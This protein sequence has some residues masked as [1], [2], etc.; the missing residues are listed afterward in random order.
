MLHVH[1]SNRLENLLSGLLDQINN[2]DPFLAEVIVVQ[3]PGMSRWLSQQIAERQGISAN[4]EFVTP[5]NFFWRA[6]QCWFD[7]LKEHPS[8]NK[9]R[10]QWQIFQLLPDFLSQS[11]FEQLAVYLR[12]DEDTLQR[13]QLSGAIANTFDQYLIYRPDLIER[14]QQGKDVHWQALLWRAI[15]KDEPAL[16]WGDIRTRFAAAQKQSPVK[17]MPACVSVFGISDLA[18]LYLDLLQII[19]GHTKTTLYYLNPCVEYWADIKDEKSL[20]RRRARAYK[21]HNSDTD[22]TGLLDIVNPLLASWGHAGQSFLDQLLERQVQET[23]DYSVPGKETLLRCL[24]GDILHLE[25]KTD[26]S[27]GTI[28]ADDHSVQIHSV[29]STLRE[30][31]VLHDQLLN[32]FASR[33]NLE[34]RDIIVMAPDIDCYAPFVDAVFGTAPSRQY[35]PWSISDRRLRSEQQLLEAFESLLQLPQSRFESTDIVSL[36]QVPAIR[37]KFG[38]DRNDLNRLR[39]WIRESGVR[40][41]LDENMRTELG[42]P[43]QRSHSWRYGLERMFLGYALPIDDGTLYEGISPYG[44]IEG[45]AS[46]QLEKLQLIIDLCSEWRKRLLRDHPA[47]DWLTEIDQLIEVFFEP[48]QKEAHA[49]QTLRDGLLSALNQSGESE[50]SIGLPVI[51]EIT[52]NILEDNASV[53]QFLT[54]RVTFSNIVPMRSIPFR[55]VCLLGMNADDFPRESRPLS[56]DL[57]MQYPR[58]GD[59]GRSNDD[60]YLFLETLLSAR[61]VLYLSYVGKD[62]RDN[63]DKAPATVLTEMLS[64]TNSSY[65]REKSDGEAVVA[66][67]HPLQPFSKRY[68]DQS[69]ARL[70]NFKSDWFDAASTEQQ[71]QSVAFID[72]DETILDP[73]SQDVSLKQLIDF[74]TSPAMTYLAERL[75]VRF[76][77]SEEDLQT[78]EQ[79]DLSALE[80]WSVDQ[81]VHF[82]GKNLPR[83]EVKQTLDAQ[84]KLP[85]GLYGDIVFE[86]SYKRAL[87]LDAR[88]ISHEAKEK[89]PPVEV[90]L[91][92]GAYTVH[93]QLSSL[94]DGGLFCW[95]SGKK[96][97]TDILSMWIKHLC[98]CAQ[99]PVQVPMLSTYV[100]ADVTLVF[101]EVNN[102]SDHLRQ[103]LELRH[104][105]LL[106]PQLFYPDASRAFAEATDEERGLSAANK[107]WFIGFESR[108]EPNAV[109]WRGMDNPFGDG[110]QQLAKSVF[111][112]I[113]QCAVETPESEEVPEE[114]P[115]DF[116]RSEADS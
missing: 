62:I 14:W 86:D 114:L 27:G 37:R 42:L 31:Q 68:F 10:L 90:A 12:G 103:L 19:A 7:D 99:K 92:I 34:P 85:Q 70:Y 109:V 75:A 72:T 53:R 111:E 41:S 102:P 74:I 28:A 73:P 59:R 47:R 88:I 55:V 33:D 89:L 66:L 60:R 95:R 80:K 26:G 84:G 83:K 40:W 16:S 107:A 93:G 115:E 64:Y 87:K 76:A 52:S 97:S 39:Q 113:L 116:S 50:L 35:I 104:R 67:Q 25:D 24:Q 6:A 2:G 38:L 18:P 30:V 11:A 32:L 36:L 100:F 22:P 112:P 81:S 65:S 57:M 54:G 45:T 5:A 105:Y 91:E 71:L 56:F 23:E 77:Y 8:R 69:H 15:A 29:H 21:L 96:R 63:T 46:E 108:Q 13:F 48:D 1:S 94:G 110:F 20:A 49:L 78:S 51:L 101:N 9:V 44:E 82:F 58:R 61:E 79:F 43:A 4:L 98:L 3:N 106:H 17:P